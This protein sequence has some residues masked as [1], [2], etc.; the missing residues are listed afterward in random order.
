MTGG[1]ESV[2]LNVDHLPSHNHSITGMSSIGRPDG[3][4]DWTGSRRGFTPNKGYGYYVN[5]CDKDTTRPTCNSITTPTNMTGNN[6]EIENMPP[7]YVLA[8][9]MKL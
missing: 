5:S 2:K 4:Q 3:G 7:Y 8:Y 6:K 1:V 9:I